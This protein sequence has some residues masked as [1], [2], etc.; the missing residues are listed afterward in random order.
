[1]R[2]NY[3]IKS[4]LFEFPVG[5]AVWLYGPIRRVGFNPK[6]QR[7]L[8]G[9]CQVIAKISDILY[10]IKQSPRH[11]SRVVH[12]DKLR[13]YRGRNLPTWFS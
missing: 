7:P 2:R 12:H 9:P 11:R 4:N 13:K 1:M 10:R 6:L 5:D 8:K 3:D